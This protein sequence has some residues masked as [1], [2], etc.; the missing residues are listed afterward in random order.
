MHLLRRFR[1]ALFAIFLLVTVLQP[2]FS[3]EESQTKPAGFGTLKD[4]PELKALKYRSIGPAWGGRVSRAAGIA[5]DPSTYYFVGAAS[6]VWKSV[7]GGHQFL[8]INRYRPLDRWPSH[9]RLPM[10]CMSVPEKQTHA[11]TSRLETEFTNRWMLEKHGNTSGR[12]KAKSEPWWF[13]QR[14]LTLLMLQFWVMP[15][16]RTQNAEYIEPKM[17]E[18]PGNKF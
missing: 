16:D 18:K 8:M 13:I 12:K 2:I 4:P 9:H 1:I 3:A 7:D 10:W 11:E 14:M 15:L 17:A 5:G 6:G